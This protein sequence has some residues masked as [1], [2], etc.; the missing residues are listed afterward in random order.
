[1][2]SNKISFEKVVIKITALKMFS[3]ISFRIN[4]YIIDILSFIYHLF[5]NIK[6]HINSTKSNLD[7]VLFHKQ[8][9]II[10]SFFCLI[11]NIHQ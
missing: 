3:K 9:L 4:A 10:Y 1:M 7:N 8:N 2:V 11:N 5:I 6:L